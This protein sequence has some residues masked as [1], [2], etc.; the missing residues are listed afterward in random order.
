MTSTQPE[1]LS[2]VV[3]GTPDVGATGVFA[4]IEVLRSVGRSWQ[5][6]HRAEPGPPRFEVVLA[7]IDGEPFRSAS[8]ILIHPLAKLGDVRPDIVVVPELILPLD[9]PLPAGYRPIAEW[10]VAAHARGAVLA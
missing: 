1:S 8:G 2:V 10:L 5:R 4:I 3:V 9:A 6:L 7:T